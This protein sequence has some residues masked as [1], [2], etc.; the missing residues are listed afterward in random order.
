MGI[1]EYLSDLDESEKDEFYHLISKYNRSK[2]RSLIRR[3]RLEELLPLSLPQNRL[4]L[5]SQLEKALNYI[6][7][8]HES[9]RTI[10]V[11]KDNQP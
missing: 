9:L 2:N 11:L 7:N 3:E 6:I 4:W 5:L 8:H 1:N 10:L